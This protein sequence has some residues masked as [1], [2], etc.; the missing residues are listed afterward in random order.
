MRRTFFMVLISAFVPV[1]CRRDQAKVTTGGPGDRQPQR[2]ARPASAQR[3]SR[4]NPGQPKDF[5]AQLPPL[6]SP[7][8]PPTGQASVPR[9]AGSGTPSVQ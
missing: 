4:S 8:G 1:A 9:P 6:G 7:I 2:A 3:T 5:G